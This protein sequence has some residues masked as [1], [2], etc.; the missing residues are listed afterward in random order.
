MSADRQGVEEVGHVGD[1]VLEQVADAAPAGQQLHRML[2]LDVRREHQ[3][4]DVGELVAD[5]LR[6]V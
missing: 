4:G 6:G 2:D 3:D 1:P 5:H